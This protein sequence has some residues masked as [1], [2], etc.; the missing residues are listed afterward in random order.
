MSPK[1]SL[2]MKNL[3]QTQYRQ[4]LSKLSVPQAGFVIFTE[5]LKK[6][7]MLADGVMFND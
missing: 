4:R 7:Q 1:P 6:F 3:R 5:S 2:K